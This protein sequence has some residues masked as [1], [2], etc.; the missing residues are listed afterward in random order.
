MWT[1][2]HVHGQGLTWAGLTTDAVQDQAVGLSQGGSQNSAWA[3]S[4]ASQ[5][6]P[7]QTPTLTWGHKL[8]QAL[9]EELD[10]AWL[11]S[12]L[13]AFL[14][15]QQ[16]RL[17]AGCCPGYTASDV[18]ASLGRGIPTSHC[19]HSF[20]SSI[21]PVP[22]WWLR[23]ELHQAA[24][25]VLPWTPLQK[26]SIAAPFLCYLALGVAPSLSKGHPL[27]HTTVISCTGFLQAASLHCGFS[28]LRGHLVSSVL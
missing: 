23:Q 1:L 28:E 10:T 17:G 20:L 7:L 21:F 5:C 26:K 11:P 14:I 9:A 6:R 24:L 22:T 18:Q 25:H 19:S 2:G 4:N 3:L 13:P 12:W 27:L 16:V 8:C 15:T